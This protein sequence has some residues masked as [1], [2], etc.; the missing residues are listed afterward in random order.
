MKSEFGTKPGVDNTGYRNDLMFGHGRVSSVNSADLEC[1]HTYLTQRIC[2]GR[3]LALNSVVSLPTSIHVNNANHLTG[4]CCYEH[5]MV[6]QH[7]PSER[8]SSY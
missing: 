7:Q 2:P 4:D 3:V 1:T 5:P 6:I 8:L